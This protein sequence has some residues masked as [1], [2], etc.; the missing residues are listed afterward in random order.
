MRSDEAKICHFHL[1]VGKHCV[2]VDDVPIV[3][4]ILPK[5]T[6]EALID[7]LHDLVDTRKKA[8][9]EV[10][11][12]FFESFRHNRMVGVRNGVGCDFPRLIP[13]VSVLVEEQTHKFGY[14]KRRVRIVDVDC[15]AVRKVVKARIGF[16]MTTQNGLY[17]RR[18]EEVLLFEAQRLALDVVVGGIKHLVNGLRH[19][20]C[21]AC[22]DVF[23]S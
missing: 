7:L 13:T 5:L 12:P 2:A 10:L 6:A 9:E 11:R 15:H 21:R 17:G 3:G 4:I 22:F 1:T 23:A 14:A 18:Y 19:R 20:F 16:E 8:L